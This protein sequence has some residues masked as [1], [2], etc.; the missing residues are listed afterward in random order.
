MSKLIKGIGK[1]VK[2]I[3][4][5]VKKV[6][7]KITSSTL[8]KV[9][10]GAAAIYLTGG[11]FGM[12][13]TP[14]S[15]I[16]G[17]FVKGATDTVAQTTLAAGTETAAAT[18]AAEGAVFADTLGSAASGTLELGASEA[19][20]N[21][22]LSNAAQSAVSSTGVAAAPTATNLAVNTATNKALGTAAT[23]AVTAGAQP[24]LLAK[25]GSG[26]V[27]FAKGVGTFAKN[28]PTAAAIGASTIAGA[29]GNDEVDLLEKEEELRAQRLRD[30]YEGVGDV[31]LGFNPSSSGLMYKS[32]GAPVYGGG[33]ILQRL[34]NASNVGK[35]G[36]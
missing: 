26:A 1:A 31:D 36:G 28:N 33:G 25:L 2:G 34:R 8:G 20:T 3:V 19:A 6:F 23:K 35:G 12:W 24:G 11:A 7:K 16:N 29:L 21:A 17:A 18:G 13:N 14:F 9:L 10:L 5:G 27:D 32:S 22:A 4:K 15:S 30:A